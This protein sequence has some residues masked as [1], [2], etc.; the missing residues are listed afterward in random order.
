MTRNGWWYPRN[1]AVR[2]LGMKAPAL[3]L[4]LVSGELIAQLTG[5]VPPRPFG[6]A[7]DAD[8]QILESQHLAEASAAVKPQQR[9]RGDQHRTYHFPAAKTDMPYRLYV[10][11]TWDGQSRLPLIVILHGAGADENRYMDMN[12]KRS[13]G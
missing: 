9:V 2:R 6:S 13:F 7:L 3:L 10:P 12:D 4:V 5:Q 11:T 1:G 8:Q